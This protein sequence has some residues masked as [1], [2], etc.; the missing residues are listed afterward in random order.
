MSQ[1]PA[2]RKAVIVQ[3]M[4]DL[5]RE[6]QDCGVVT[7]RLPGIVEDLVRR[8]VDLAEARLEMPLGYVAVPVGAECPECVRREGEGERP[9]LKECRDCG[10]LYREG[11]HDQCPAAMPPRAGDSLGPATKPE[12][13][14]FADNAIVE[15]IR[16]DLAEMRRKDR[17]TLQ[18]LLDDAFREPASDTLPDDA[19]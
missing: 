17:A 13:P 1:S 19:P 5:L 16:A 6:L 14:L 11:E 3:A 8:Q 12:H 18:A 9:G 7:D 2:Y 4:D 15:K 10:A